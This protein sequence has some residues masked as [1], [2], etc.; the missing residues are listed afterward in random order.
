MGVIIVIMCTYGKKSQSE[1]TNVPY[2]NA[3]VSKELIN[4]MGKMFKKW[5]SKPNV[6]SQVLNLIPSLRFYTEYNRDC[7]SDGNLL[8]FVIIEKPGRDFLGNFPACW[9]PSIWDA[10]QLSKRN[11]EQ[12]SPTVKSILGQ[13]VTVAAVVKCKS[14]TQQLSLQTLINLEIYHVPRMPSA[15]AEKELPLPGLRLLTVSV[16][17]N[18]YTFSLQVHLSLFFFFFLI[19]IGVK[20]A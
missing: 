10:I 3:T 11:S 19:E 9:K 6:L 20:Y 4:I 15:L 2:L 8:G 1:K 5:S 16:Y 18:S 14:K 12:L 13:Y 7:R 17:C